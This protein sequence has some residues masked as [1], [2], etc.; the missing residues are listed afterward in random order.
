[1]LR[2][3]HSSLETLPAEKPKLSTTQRQPDSWLQDEQ[4]T[5]S[6][7]RKETRQSTDCKTKQKQICKQ[8]LKRHWKQ[9][10]NEEHPSGLPILSLC[11]ENNEEVCLL[12]PD[13]V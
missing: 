10:G 1:M 2:T 8:G 6:A 4:K 3:R 5:A 12:Q 9:H 11:Q 7:A 13:L